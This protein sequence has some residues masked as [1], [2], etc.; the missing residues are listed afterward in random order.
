MGIL[1]FRQRSGARARQSAK[2]RS[3]DNR[4]RPRLEALEDRRLL[5]AAAF[6]PTIVATASEAPGNVVGTTIP[7]DS[8]LLTGVPNGVLGEITFTLV[9]PDN[10]VAD[11]EAFLAPVNGDYT[12]SNVNAATQVGTYTW[13]VHYADTLGNSADDQG[14]PAQQVTTFKTRPMITINPG[15]T[16]RIASG[17]RLTAAATLSMGFNPTGTITF[18]AFSPGGAV[19]DVETVTV[20]GNGTYT[21]PSGLVPTAT[22]TYHW[23]QAI[24]SGDGKNNQAISLVSAAPETVANSTTIITTLGEVDLVTFENLADPRTVDNTV[25]VNIVYHNLLG[26]QPDQAG[27][28]AAFHYLQAGGSRFQFVQNVW[29]SAEH[30]DLEVEQFYVSILHRTAAPAE[31]AGWVNAF[32]AGASETDVAA[33]FLSSS[34]YMSTHSNNFS[35][36]GG[37][38]QDVLRRFPDPTDLLPWAQALSNGL[39]RSAAAQA[40]LNSDEYHQLIVDQFYIEYLNRA[41]DAASEQGWLTFMRTGGTIETTAEMFLTSNEYVQH[42]E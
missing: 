25:L 19:V 20:H 16:V 30:R 22:G 41:P 34:E 10:T 21:T 6:G 17:A 29:R 26:R 1:G 9:A 3:T 31:R 39:S 42:L 27:F 11:Q 7:Q 18:T 4:F 33:A 28:N 5:T 35:F 13:H 32:L 2:R 24:Y 36:V 23:G 37:L 38:Y 15:G 12:T 8:A 14:G 40:F